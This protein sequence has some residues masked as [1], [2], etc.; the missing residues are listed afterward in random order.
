MGENYQVEP[1]MFDHPNNPKRFALAGFNPIQGQIS[2]E[3]MDRTR[4]EI[5][6]KV[7]SLGGEY[8]DSDEWK[9]RVTH[10]V[11]HLQPDK[12]GLPEKVMGAIAAGKFVVTKV[13]CNYWRLLH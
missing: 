6:R 2:V 7:E 13:S 8:V 4:A 9:D 1:W 12:E 3:E 11:A 10:V 5:V